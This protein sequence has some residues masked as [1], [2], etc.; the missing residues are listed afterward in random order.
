[1]RESVAYRLYLEVSVVRVVLELVLRLVPPVELPFD[2]VLVR[3]PLVREHVSYHQNKPA[4]GN[5]GSGGGGRGKAGPGSGAAT[6]GWRG[7][8]G[9]GVTF[10]LKTRE[11]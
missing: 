5:D 4:R 10:G 6:G 2:A 8:K 3:V 11:G 9:E 1:M 7:G